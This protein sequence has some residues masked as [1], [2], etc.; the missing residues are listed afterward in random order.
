MRKLTEHMINECNEHLSIEVID[1]PGQGN[2]SHRY[3]MIVD[4]GEH[5]DQHL[6][7]QN[8]AIDEVGTN[9]VTHEALLAII[10][11]R[12]RAFQKSDFGCRENAITITKL[13]EALMWQHKRTRDREARGV[14]GTL[15]P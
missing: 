11:D 6:Q 2:A 1:P 12:M 10:L 4:N 7:F 13:E 9:G 8:G 14:E 3:R 15:T 5:T